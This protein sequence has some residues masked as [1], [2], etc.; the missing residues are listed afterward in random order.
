MFKAEEPEENPSANNGGN[1]MAAG[2]FSKFGLGG[3]G[4][5][6]ASHAPLR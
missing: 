1:S 5:S 3:G 6:K 4:G 2:L